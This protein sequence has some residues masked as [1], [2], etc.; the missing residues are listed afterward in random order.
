L[1]IARAFSGEVVGCDALQVYRG[2]NVGTA[3]LSESERL[4][5]AH[6]LLDVADPNDEYSAARYAVEAAAAVRDIADRGRLPIVVGGTGLYLRALRRGLFAGPGRSPALRQRLGT[7][8]AR[9]GGPR[10]HA[11]LTRRDPV[12]AERI[13]PNDYVRIVRALEVTLLTARPMSELMSLRQSPLHDFETV[14]L[15][16]ALDKDVLSSRVEARVR[17]MFESGLVEEVELLRAR[18]GDHLPAFKAIGYREV[19][20]ALRGEC[21]LAHA[22]EMTIR[23]TL[24]YAKRQMTWFRSEDGI[25]WLRGA[26]DEPR[27]Q[28]EA[29]EKLYC[30][31]TTIRSESTHAETAS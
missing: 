8:I 2:L 23:A 31:R 3:K 16:L 1:S 22:E 15:G 6:H 11:L 25:Q 10:L 24:R 13:H 7:I 4:G 20:S 27:I 29:L 9:G 26:G 12:S 17:E 30:L 14:L 5:V 19:V 21:D 18:F 28:R